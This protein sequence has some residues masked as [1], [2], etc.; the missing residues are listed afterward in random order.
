MKIALKS[1]APK[2]NISL[3][4]FNELISGL[5]IEISEQTK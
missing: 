4:K 1:I 5:G 2:G 3:Q